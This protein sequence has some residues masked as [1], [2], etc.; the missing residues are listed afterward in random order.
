MFH[1]NSLLTNILRFHHKLTADAR[2][3]GCHLAE[4]EVDIVHSL[5]DCPMAKQ[6]HSFIPSCAVVAMGTPKHDRHRSLLSWMWTVVPL[7]ILVELDLEDFIRSPKGAFLIGCYAKYHKHGVDIRKLLSRNWVGIT[8]GGGDAYNTPIIGGS[9][10]FSITGGGGGRDAVGDGEGGGVVVVHNYNGNGWVEEEKVAVAVYGDK[11]VA[12]VQQVEA[13]VGM[14]NVEM[15]VDGK[16][17]WEVVV[18]QQM[19]F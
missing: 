8:E 2:C 16:T 9:G 14:Q 18:M 15:L 11:S 10:V 13:V 1:A 3:G 7:A 19:S 12:V 6:K 4:E 5:R 17:L